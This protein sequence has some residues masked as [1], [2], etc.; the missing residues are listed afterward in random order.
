MY[1]NFDRHEL[2]NANLVKFHSNT[3]RQ[4]EDFFLDSEEV[5]NDTIN[6]LYGIWDGYLYDGLVSEAKNS[7]LPNE[8]VL[9]IEAIVDRIN[10]SIS[11]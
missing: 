11:K 4:V 1:K 6:M 7:G 3:I 9:R 5:F 2:F 10:F 8:L